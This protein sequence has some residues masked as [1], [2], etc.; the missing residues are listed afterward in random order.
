MSR[1]FRLGLFVV[2][3][4]LIFAGGVFL[5]GSKK[6]YFQQSYRL[7]ANFQNVAGLDGGA[8]V[9]VGGFHQGSVTRIDLP[10]HPDEGVTV[11]MD[12]AKSTHQVIRKD[13]VAS[14]VS[15]GMVG[16]RYVEITFGS[17]GAAEIKDGD[18]IQGAP[19]V[20]MSDLL[21][22]ADQVLDTASNAVKGIGASADN[23]KSISAKID[24]GQGTVGALVNDKTIYKAAAAGA[25]E[26]QED[27]EALKHNFFLRGFFNKR[28]Y[29]D[30]AA[31]KQ[32]EV[33]ELPPAMYERRLVYDSAKIFDK[34]DTAK[35]KHEQA[36]NDAGHFLEQ[37]PFG[38]AVVAAHTGMKGDTQKN[39][40]LTEAQSMVVRDYLA[41][42]FKLDDT[43]LKTLGLGE[44]SNIDA[45][46]VEIFVYPVETGAKAK[47][48]PPPAK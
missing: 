10:K 25:T 46:Q 43:R 28:G 33:A 11:T 36:L 7:R 15:E 13:S 45:N 23:L 32:H 17:K 3:T 38:L 37:E 14:I 41:K 5:I 27:M 48:S 22:K 26:F 18:T 42:N 1:T 30:S 9:R 19:P 35:L 4:L 8:D 31:L 39:R 47:K 6:M 44:D 24:S 29:Q 21:K 34:P 16:D 2:A 40:E 12:L 20:Q